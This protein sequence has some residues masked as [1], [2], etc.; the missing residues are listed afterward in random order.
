[1][2]SM[3]D[4]AGAQVYP[5]GAIVVSGEVVSRTRDTIIVRLKKQGLSF[6]AI[7]RI[8]NVTRQSVHERYHSIPEDVRRYYATVSL[9]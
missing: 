3:V 5:V 9:G 1:M 6:Q 7:G 4:R 2:A 8:L